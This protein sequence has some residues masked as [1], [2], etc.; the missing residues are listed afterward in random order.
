[1]KTFCLPFYCMISYYD[2]SME[3]PEKAVCC[4]LCLCMAVAVLSSVSLVYLTAI[5]QRIVSFNPLTVNFW[6]P[7]PPGNS[8]RSDVVTV[9]YHRRRRRKVKIKVT[10]KRRHLRY[11]RLRYSGAAGEIRHGRSKKHEVFGRGDG[12]RICYSILFED[13]YN[14]TKTIFLRE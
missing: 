8:V 9:E 2:R 1:M 4:S 7:P 6:P 3:A 14:E 13:F 5:G 10:T 11:G 12:E